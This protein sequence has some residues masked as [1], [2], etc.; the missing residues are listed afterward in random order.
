MPSSVASSKLSG[1]T[2]CS[3]YTPDELYVA[4]NDLLSTKGNL[5]KDDVRDFVKKYFFP[6]ESMVKIETPP[7]WTETPSILHAINDSQL[8]VHRIAYL[9]LTVSSLQMVYDSSVFFV[10]A[11]FLCVL[12]AFCQ[13]AE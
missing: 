5:S 7:D 10:C 8:Q 2:S 9:S 11:R 1:M 4:F 13:R 12:A 3:T 6:P